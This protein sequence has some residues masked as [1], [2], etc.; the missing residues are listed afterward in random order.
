VKKPG[1]PEDIAYTAVFLAAEASGFITG[2]TFPVRGIGV[3]SRD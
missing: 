2:E 1:Q 3:K